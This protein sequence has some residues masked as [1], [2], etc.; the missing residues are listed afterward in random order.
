LDAERYSQA[1]NCESAAF[2]NPSRAAAKLE[3]LRSETG[4]SG[5]TV[6]EA[7]RL[8]AGRRLTF[9]RRVRGFRRRSSACAAFGFPRPT[10]TAHELGSSPIPDAQGRI[11]AKAYGVSLEWLMNGILPS[12]LGAA[13]DRRL[14]SDPIPSEET[15]DG[16][17][18]LA[19]RYVAPD[20]A[21]LGV[22][23]TFIHEGSTGLIREVVPDYENENGISELEG[24]PRYWSLPEDYDLRLLGARAENIVVL[25]NGRGG[26][27]FVDALDRDVGKRG[28]FLYVDG[29][30]RP[31]IVPQPADPGSTT[32]KRL[33]GRVLAEINVYRRG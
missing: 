3:Q 17:A 33:V 15:A 27:L 21:G 32:G 6:H 20:R 23:K 13:V 1:F 10:L 12:G 4:S 25:P 22:P 31:A 14:R 8:D 16:L 29:N 7:S 19:D 30:S 9:A 24:A 11:Y 18:G 5:P 26:R 28:D 2:Q